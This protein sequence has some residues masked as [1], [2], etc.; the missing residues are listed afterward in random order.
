MTTTGEV[1]HYVEGAIRQFAEQLFDR[2]LSRFFDRFGR[3]PNGCEPVFF[4]HEEEAPMP[5]AA[6]E[7][8]AL[9]VA[10]TQSDSLLAFR[11]EEGVRVF[12]ILVLMQLGLPVEGVEDALTGT[13]V[14][15]LQ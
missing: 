9:V 11:S 3:L 15:Q 7:I 14:F 6:P 5:M 8:L 2:Q 4:V 12:A 13:G 1:H 10:E